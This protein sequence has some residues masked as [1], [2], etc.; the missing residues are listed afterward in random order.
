MMELPTATATLWMVLEACAQCKLP[1]G[2]PDLNSEAQ[3]PVI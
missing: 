3:D 2:T 1:I